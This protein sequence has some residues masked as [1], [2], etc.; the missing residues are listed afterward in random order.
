[1]PGLVGD[2]DAMRRVVALAHRVAPT[3]VTVLIE[4]E[5]GTGKEVIAR[6]LHRLSDRADGPFIALNCGA[7]PKELL[8]SELF[9]H[10]RGAFSGANRDRKGMFALASGGTVFLDE[11]GEMPQ[12]AQVRLLRFLDDH[13]VRPVGSEH[14]TQCDVRVLAATN[15]NLDDLLREGKFRDDLLYR[16]RHIAID[17][18]PLRERRGDVELIAK[19][20]LEKEAEAHNRAN[21]GFTDAA[22]ERLR[23]HDWPGNV[24]ELKA[25][26][27]R[28]LIMTPA[29]RPI[30]AGD[31]QLRREGTRQLATLED[32]ERDAIRRA[33]S[34]ED[35]RE[36]AAKR[37]G[38][39]A[40]TLYEKIKNTAWGR[41]R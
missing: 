23:A 35:T 18:P 10:V 30:D 40:S 32:V 25:C 20:V 31:L 11:I 28:A 19:Y 38:I 26:V 3:N 1:M 41:S 37:L 27:V 29:G 14:E 8:E 13:R 5:T 2:S 34:E 33:L 17:L 6:G 4:G 12:D 36:K 24:R 7:I 16:L 39:A 9:G 22:H 21:P 15:R